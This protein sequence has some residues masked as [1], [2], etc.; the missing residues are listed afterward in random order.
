[1]EMTA[2]EYDRY[3]QTHLQYGEPMEPGYFIVFRWEKK[4]APLGMV[5]RK[6]GPRGGR[7]TLRWVEPE[8]G[9]HVRWNHEDW[10]WLLWSRW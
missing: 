1:M 3:L 5:I 8:K 9:A 7:G 2:E 6:R 4:E 10:H